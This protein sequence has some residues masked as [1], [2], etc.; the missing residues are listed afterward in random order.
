MA[1][2]LN[3]LPPSPYSPRRIASLSS[4]RAGD[5]MA[6]PPAP[7]SPP[8]Q[9]P[10]VLSREP[11]ANMASGDNTGVGVGPGMNSD[12]PSI[13]LQTKTQLTQCFPGPLRHPRPLTAADLHMQLEKEQ[14]A[15][16][17]CGGRST[18]WNNLAHYSSLLG[19]PPHSRALSS[20]PAVCFSGIDDLLRLCRSA[21][22]HRS[23]C[24]PSDF[25]A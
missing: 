13:H 6:P 15:V 21:R 10:T 9:S 14:E 4:R 5:T 11:P 16:V 7:T 25:R 23:K 8:A 20:T 3:S 2:D 19:Q 17:S 18:I 1:P 24:K 22:C 12:T